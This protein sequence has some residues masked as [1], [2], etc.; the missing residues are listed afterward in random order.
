MTLM[1]L[2]CIDVGPM[3]PIDFSRTRRRP[4]PE[5]GPTAAVGPVATTGG[6]LVREAERVLRWVERNL[7][8][9]THAVPMEE[10]E[11]L[12][13]VMQPHVVVVPRN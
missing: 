2:L 5:A 8:A 3:R 7:T 13:P 11:D 6:P 10:I 9:L 12:P 1:Y 4:R